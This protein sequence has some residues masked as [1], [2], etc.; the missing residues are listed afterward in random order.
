MVIFL[1]TGETFTKVLIPSGRHYFLHRLI[2]IKKDVSVFLLVFHFPNADFSLKGVQV[3]R[4]GLGPAPDCGEHLCSLS[5]RL[6]I[7]RPEG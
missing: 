4:E 6:C 1:V 7:P 5:D 2:R 3:P